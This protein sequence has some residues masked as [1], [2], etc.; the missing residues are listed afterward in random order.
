M[1]YRYHIFYTIENF[2]HKG[3]EY[4]LIKENNIKKFKS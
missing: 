4:V 1:H 2:I 3:M